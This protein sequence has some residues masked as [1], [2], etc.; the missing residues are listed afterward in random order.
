MADLHMATISD[1]L[2]EKPD[3]QRRPAQGARSDSLRAT[4]RDG[5]HESRPPTGDAPAE[6]E[7][8]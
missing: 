2:A 8:S 5:P 1:G 6:L 7:D 3:R 4:I